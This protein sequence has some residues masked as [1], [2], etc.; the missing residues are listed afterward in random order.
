[1][2]TYNI[3]FHGEIRKILCEKP[4]YLG[5][6]ISIHYVLIHANNCNNHLIWIYSLP[7]CFSFLTYILIWK[8]ECR[9]HLNARKDDSTS[10]TQDKRVKYS[11]IQG[12]DNISYMLT[13]SK[14][15]RYS[16]ACAP[17]KFDKISNTLDFIRIN[18]VH[19]PNIP[20]FHVKS[21]KNT[22]NLSDK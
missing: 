10:K 2:S 17:M 11:F 7:I 5:L 13:V 9:M 1:M 16:P 14:M 12:N 19:N 6:W 3:W 15:G 8:S 22:T 18:L 20:C 21:R 4:Y